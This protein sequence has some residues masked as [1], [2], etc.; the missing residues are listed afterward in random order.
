MGQG[1]TQAARLLVSITLARLLVPEDFGLM[2][3]AGVL[4]ALASVFATLGVGPTIVQHPRPSDRLLRSLATLGVAVG[5]AISLLLLAV[6]GAVARF[7]TEPRVLWVVPALGTTF[8][9]GSF[10]LVPGALLQRD[11]RI[12]RLVSIDVATLVVSATVAITLAAAGQGVWAL[13]ASNIAATSVRAALLVVSSPWRLRFGFDWEAT[14]GVAGFSAGVLGFGAMHYL[15]QNVDKLLIGRRLG[16]VQLGYYEYA[17]RLYMYAVD[18]IT[19]VMIRVMFPTLARLQDQPYQLGQTFL[20]ANGAIALLT[21][22][23]MTGLA[24]LAEPAV[25]VVLGQKWAAIVPLVSIFAPVGILN[26][27]AATPGQLFLAR[28]KA[29]LRFW[30]SVI[31]TAFIVT[32]IIVGTRWGVIGVAAAVAIVIVPINAVY[33]WLALRLVDLGLADLLRTLGRTIVATGVMGAAVAALRLVLELGRAPRELVLAL[34]VAFGMGVYITVTRWLRPA[35]IGDVFRLLP[36]PL[37]RIGAIRWMF[38]ASPT[39]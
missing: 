32:A 26:S 23:L 15:N 7:Y 12:Q 19:G 30:W 4:T 39:S 24:V 37:R 18:S 16:A 5:F 20:R 34:C 13:V 22:P 33:Y 17:Y 36:A 1:A 14:R 6:S 10:G 29:G 9:L 21:F 27:I 2:G 25:I 11:L 28:G 31:Y 8:A 3:M 35:A 38:C